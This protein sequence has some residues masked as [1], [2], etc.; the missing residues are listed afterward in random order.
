MGRKHALESD[1][2]WLCHLLTVQLTSL[3]ACFFICKIKILPAAVRVRFGYEYVALKRGLL[4]PSWEMPEVGSPGFLRW[5]WSTKSSD[6]RFL[7]SWWP[8]SQS[9]QGS[10]RLLEFQPSCLYSSL[11]HMSSIPRGKTKEERVKEGPRKLLCDKS[12]YIQNITTQQSPA[13]RG[14]SAHIVLSRATL[15]PA[16]KL[17]PVT[18]LEGEVD[19][20]ATPPISF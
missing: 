20:S 3:S 7:V 15:C 13:G 16:K 12:V 4:P 11:G 2:S 10:E 17:G 19:R 6:T 5:L 14:R 9:P 8:L 1:P 18:G